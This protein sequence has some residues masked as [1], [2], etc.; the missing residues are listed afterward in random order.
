MKFKPGDSVIKKTGGN[1][2]K[3]IEYASSSVVKC[4]WVS[5]LY[6]ES[7]FDENQLVLVSEYKSLLNNYKRED[8]I[9]EIL[10]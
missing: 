7:S 4:A 1:K 5:E 8:V 10:K 2:M 9:N 6:Q 3:V